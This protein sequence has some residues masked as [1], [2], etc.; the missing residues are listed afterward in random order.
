VLTYRTGLKSQQI[1][2]RSLTRA[3]SIDVL[4]LPGTEL[5]RLDLGDITGTSVT[6][7]LD[8]FSTT[9][10]RTIAEALDF[11]IRRPTVERNFSQRLSEQIW[12]DYTGLRVKGWR[13][14]M[15]H[16]LGMLGKTFLHIFLPAI[17]L[18]G[19]ALAWAYITHQPIFR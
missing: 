18:T 3:K 6:L 10:R 14:H 16:G 15:L 13:N 12:P 17:L 9:D 11:F 19:I 8:D 5:L 2:L 7:R 4:R 1:Q